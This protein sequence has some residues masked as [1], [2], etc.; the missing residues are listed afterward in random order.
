MSNSRK[1]QVYIMI[2]VFAFIAM[3]ALMTFA[4][5][6]KCKK[7]LRD[8]PTT[9]KMLEKKVS[10][11]NSK[12]RTMKLNIIAA[13]NSKSSIIEV[14]KAKP[15]LVKWVYKH[16]HISNSMAKEVV[17]NISKASYPLFL[18]ALIKT[19]SN[20]NPTAVSNK[21]AMGLGQIMPF[22]EKVLVE[23]GI[24]EEMRDIF[25]IPIAIKATEFIWETKMLKARGDINKALALYLGN[26]DRGYVN[27]ILRDYF[28]L[29][30]LC[31]EPLVGEKLISKSQ[32]A[33]ISSI[34]DQV[35]RDRNKKKNIYTVEKG[36]TLS[37]IV[38]MVY[39]ESNQNIL[40]SIKSINPEIKDIALIQIGQKI[41]LPSIYVR[42]VYIVPDLSNIE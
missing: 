22:H 21:G 11:L 38:I 31:K 15:Q 26:N 16:S 7:Q 4:G 18:L 28:Q 41:V 3:A 36:D 6:A 17:N 5:F 20:F 24:L 19:E 25:N 14:N 10:E 30:Y 34:E 39:G 40:E 27:Q 8:R 35:S 29:T 9:V 2:T 37:K 13:K 1:F 33:A 42:N 32:K 23:A 12:I